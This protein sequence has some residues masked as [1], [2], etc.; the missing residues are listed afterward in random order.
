MAGYR[1]RYM[2]HMTGLP[3]WIRF[4]FNP[5]WIGRSQTGLPPAAQYLMEAGQ[6]PH[7]LCGPSCCNTG[8]G[9]RYAFD[10]VA[11]GA[12]SRNARGPG[13][14]FRATVGTDQETS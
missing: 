3:G 12:R 5:G 1:H 8:D 11:R 9:R 10:S 4:G 13:K 6:M 2:Y 14:D 7:V